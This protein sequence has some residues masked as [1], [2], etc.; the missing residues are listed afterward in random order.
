M[1]PAD[2][3]HPETVR[4]LVQLIKDGATGFVVTSDGAVW[5][6]AT[7]IIRPATLDTSKVEAFREALSG[8]HTWFATRADV[9]EY[10]KPA[11][12]PLRTVKPVTAPPSPIATPAR[13]KPT[14]NQETFF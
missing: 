14:D 4:W 3:L 9:D 13:K 5:D 12:K 11:V 8:N 7:E 10:L 1:P 2:R 6:I